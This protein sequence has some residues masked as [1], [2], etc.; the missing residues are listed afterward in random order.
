MKSKVPRSDDTYVRE[1]NIRQRKITLIGPSVS[2]ARIHVCVDVRFPT[3]STQQVFCTFETDDD[4]NIETR[5]KK[6]T[7]TYAHGRGLVESILFPHARNM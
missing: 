4:N 1:I 7:G 6:K 3:E 2:L 5:L